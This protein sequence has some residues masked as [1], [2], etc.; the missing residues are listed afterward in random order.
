MQ[1][2]VRAK[3]TA[4]RG[5]AMRS[6]WSRWQGSDPVPVACGRETPL[7]GDQ[8]FPPAWREGVDRMLGLLLPEGSIPDMTGAW[9][10]APLDDRE[11]IGSSDPADARPA[12]QRGES[13]PAGPAFLEASTR[14]T[15]S[16][17]RS[18]V[19]GNVYYSGV[20]ID[21][22]DAEWTCSSTRW[23]RRWSSSW[24]LRSPWYARR[25]QPGAR[26]PGFLPRLQ[27]DHRT[28]EAEFVY[29]V[30]SRSWMRYCQV[31]TIFG[32][33][34]GSGGGRR[35]FGV[36]RGGSARVIA[37]PGEHSGDAAGKWRRTG[38]LRQIGG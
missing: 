5:C 33:A 34:G 6:G 26:R 20:G 15:S 21:N 30:L 31:I 38:S 14:S 12:D 22:K 7:S 35:R 24:A 29:Q 11:L 23:R 10:P 32:T 25:H 3:R 1:S 9:R 16:A 2:T 27:G 19:P 8:E 37:D 13:G 18:P 4:S 36:S 17:A 28:P